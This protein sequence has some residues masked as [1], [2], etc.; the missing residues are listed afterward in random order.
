MGTFLS[1]HRD[2]KKL[3]LKNYLN[4][5]DRTILFWSIGIR[6]IL[7]HS[8]FC[9]CVSNGYINLM[10]WIE[11]GRVETVKEWIGRC[12]EDCRWSSGK[13]GISDEPVSFIAIKSCNIEVLDWIYSRNEKC[14][15]NHYYYATENANLKVLKWLHPKYSHFNFAGVIESAINTGKLDILIWIREDFPKIW[16]HFETYLVEP[17]YIKRSIELAFDCGQLEIF[18][19]FEK[20][21]PDKINKEDLMLEYYS[22]PNEKR[23][24]GNARCH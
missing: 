14:F 18:K 17:N 3:I 12:W 5:H 20:I 8:F 22:F 21:Y 9:N 23:Q 6:G 19:W 1:I 13:S 11:C 7:T 4:K 15:E 16:K 24:K 10:N 2:A